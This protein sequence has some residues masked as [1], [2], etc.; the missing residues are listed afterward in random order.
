MGLLNIPKNYGTPR[1]VETD[2]KYERYMKGTYPL[3][4]FWQDNVCHQ[5]KMHEKIRKALSV[6]S[7]LET[8]KN[9]NKCTII[10][11]FY[12]TLKITLEHLSIYTVDLLHLSDRAVLAP[13][14]SESKDRRGGAFTQHYGE[15]V[16]KFGS[17]SALLHI[18]H[19]LPIWIPWIFDEI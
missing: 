13:S 6:I 17:K 19:F 3:P 15:I 12:L 1:S 18:L 7:V 4:P 16:R 11:E 10:V 9:K 2:A 8:N 5:N 14:A